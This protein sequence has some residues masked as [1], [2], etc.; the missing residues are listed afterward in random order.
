MPNGS[1]IN[2]LIRCTRQDHEAE[3]LFD[4]TRPDLGLWVLDLDYADGD[5]Q[6]EQISEICRQLQANSVRLQKLREGS[7]DYTLHLN[8][9]LPERER[10][11][12]P[13]TLCR[14]ASDCG[15]NLE[16][17]ASRDEEG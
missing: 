9:D 3:G 17:Y 6:A 4:L 16:L 5:P 2:A 11:V 8:F 1:I 12:L 7:D 14:L 15:F 10:I 13:P